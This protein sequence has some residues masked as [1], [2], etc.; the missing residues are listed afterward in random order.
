MSDNALDPGRLTGLE[1]TPERLREVAEA[2]ET[3][4]FEIE[5]LRALDLGETPPAVVYRPLRPPAAP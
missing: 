1:L 4:R 5:K 3:I 2:F